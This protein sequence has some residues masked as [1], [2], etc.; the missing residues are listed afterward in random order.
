MATGE[1]GELVPE[2][3]MEFLDGIREH[4]VDKTPTYSGVTISDK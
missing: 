1:C 4:K 3:V 2:I